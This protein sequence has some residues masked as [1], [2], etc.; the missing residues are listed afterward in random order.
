MYLCPDA[1]QVSK[2]LIFPIGIRG[3][4]IRLFAR[5]ARE[6]YLLEGLTADAWELVITHKV[7][8]R[9]KAASVIIIPATAGAEFSS[10][11][12][13]R[14]CPCKG[15]KLHPIFPPASDISVPGLRRC[16]PR[17]R[18]LFACLSRRI[19]RRR[20]PPGAS[21][22]FSLCCTSGYCFPCCRSG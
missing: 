13:R 21:P 2:A 15:Y 8:P 4:I 6:H 20:W 17:Y 1:F 3:L 14:S 22:S 18:P 5:C 12:N 9:L 16:W 7:L 11:L 10:S 19:G